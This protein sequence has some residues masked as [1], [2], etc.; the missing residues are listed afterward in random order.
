MARST[1]AVRL[2]EAMGKGVMVGSEAQLEAM[3][4]RIIDGN[5]YMT[6]ATVGEDGRPWVTP[7]YF[8]PDGYR[9]MYWI[10]SPEARHSRNLAIQPAVSIVVFDSQV[11]IGE[12]VY[13]RAHAQKI[14]EPTSEECAIAF[15][16]RFEGVKAFGPDELRPPAKLRLYRATVTEHWVLIRGDD[17]VW[18]RGTDSR[19][20]VSL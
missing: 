16:P 14:M 9:H 3:A 4:R 11:R 13:M 12:A 6:I 17:P 8:N 19:V 7:V 18:R 10:S 5:R 20:A 15:Q 2:R 1:N